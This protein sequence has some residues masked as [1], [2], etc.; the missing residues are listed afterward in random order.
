MANQSS[1][2]VS[3]VIFDCDGVL[4]DTEPV[5]IRVLTAQLQG[6]GID[7]TYEQCTKEFVGLSQDATVR[8]ISNRL[9]AEIPP[10]WLDDLIS[11]SIR[12]LGPRY[13]PLPVS[14]MCW[15]V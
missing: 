6:L 4:V 11:P 1:G 15:L 10:G 9:G 12:R 8:L 13:A 5:V 3:L 14:L 2:P 7:I